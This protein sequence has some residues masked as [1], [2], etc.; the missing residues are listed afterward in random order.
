MMRRLAG[1]SCSQ[2]GATLWLVPVDSAG[3]PLRRS[4][5]LPADHTWLT[6]ADDPLSS[7]DA[8]FTVMWEN[9][10]PFN[11]KVHTDT[12]YYSCSFFRFLISNQIIFTHVLKHMIRKQARGVQHATGGNRSAPQ[13]GPIWPTWT[14]FSDSQFKISTLSILFHAFNVH[15][16]LTCC[17]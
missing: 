11:R 9:P 3:S 5:R 2:T 7:S 14:I 1:G 8:A 17:I 13:K 16:S 10:A 6:A 12:E 15:N 4:D